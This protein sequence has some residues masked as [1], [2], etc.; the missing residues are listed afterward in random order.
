MENCEW[1]IVKLQ[2][3]AKETDEAID[4]AGL[5]IDFAVTCNFV[6]ESFAGRDGTEEATREFDIHFEAGIVGDEMARINDKFLID[7]AFRKAAVSSDE[8]QSLS[9]DFELE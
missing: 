9:R 4:A 1:R 7:H 3:G 8:H 5:K 6:D 2:F